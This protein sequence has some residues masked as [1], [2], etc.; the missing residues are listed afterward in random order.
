[1]IRRATARDPLRVAVLVSGAGTNLQALIDAFGGDASPVRLVGVASTRPAVRALERAEQAGI[2]R[3]VFARTSTA[4]G[5]DARLSAWLE[6][7][8][9]E[10]VVCAGWL[11]LLTPPLLRR[12]PCL[13]VHPALSPA[14]PGLRAVEQALAYGVAVTGV[15]VF[16]LDEGVDTGPVVLQEP[17]RVHY[18]DTAETLLARLHGVEHRLI[19][20]AVAALAADRVDVRERR[21]RINPPVEAE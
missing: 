4:E 8:E 7:R 2:P 10:L 13:N 11:G 6:A 17:V 12:F 21:V 19:V 15:T 9:T 1:M 5:R 3:A 20:E 14:F 16:L 18:D